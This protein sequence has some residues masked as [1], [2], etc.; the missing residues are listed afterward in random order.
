[1]MC[2]RWR[3]YKST[4]PQESGGTLPP[5]RPSPPDFLSDNFSGTYSCV[6]RLIPTLPFSP[7][8]I[9]YEMTVVCT[10]VFLRF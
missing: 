3:A 2:H 6:L 9:K 10:L 1:M 7:P 5:P 8:M 4:S